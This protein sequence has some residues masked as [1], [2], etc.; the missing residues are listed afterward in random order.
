MIGKT[1]PTL[2]TANTWFATRLSSLYFCVCCQV[3]DFSYGSALR[4]FCLLCRLV[5][6]RPSAGAAVAL[7][8]CVSTC[9]TCTFLIISQSCKNSRKVP[10]GSIVSDLILNRYK[11]QNPD[12]ESHAAHFAYILPFVE[13]IYI[14]TCRQVGDYGRLTA[15]HLLFRNAAID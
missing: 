11:P 4:T 9:V 8:G 14:L 6:E 12:R 1:I 10:E 13:C 2:D 5:L 3:T 7:H 15:A